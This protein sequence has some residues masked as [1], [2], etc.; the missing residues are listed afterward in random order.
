MASYHALKATMYI[1]TSAASFY[2]GF[3]RSYESF[4]C[5]K[6]WEKGCLCRRQK[7]SVSHLRYRCQR[8]PFLPSKL[9]VSARRLF[10][11]GYKM[12]TSCKLQ[13]HTDSWGWP[14]TISHTWTE[15]ERAEERRWGWTRVFL[16]RVRARTFV[17]LRH[18][19]RNLCQ[20]F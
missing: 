16:W 8:F 18:G 5:E 20:G 13:T 17:T 10:G 12:G 7:Q 15:C 11:M 14:W 6:M 19:D 9:L 2:H 4:S 1:S 3:R